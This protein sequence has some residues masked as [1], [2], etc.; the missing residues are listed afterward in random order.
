MDWMHCA[1][2]H[3]LKV[4][5]LG[6]WNESGWNALWYEDMR[7][8]LNSA[9]YTKTQLVAADSFPYPI[10]TTQG[11]ADTWSVA[12]TLRTDRA[13]NAA[14]GVLGAHDVCG[15]PTTGYTCTTT[16]AARSLGKPLWASELGHMDGN[17]GAADMIRSI[18]NGYNQANLTGFLTWPLVSAMPHILPKS[19]YGL[20]NADQPWNGGYTV[21]EMTWA[22]A[23]VTQFTSPGWH[24]IAGANQGLS[25]SGSYNALQSPDHSDWSLIA[26]TS[27]AAAAQNITVDISGRLAHNVVNVWTTN[28]H[29]GPNTAM[30]K[31]PAVFPHGN[32][33][34]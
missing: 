16:E 17:A 34:T 31:Q 8:A 19:T 15:Y 33:F 3:G 7:A 2:S 23:Q 22:I 27:T 28:L 24:Y 25:A 10:G 21:N 12:K 32:T 6:G 13:F 18:I 30:I 14:V 29:G 1:S 5:Y 11:A 4:S 9:G 20:I 26:Q